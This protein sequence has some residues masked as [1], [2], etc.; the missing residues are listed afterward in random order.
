MGNWLA[1]SLIGVPV[2]L[3]HWLLF[4][5]LFIFFSGQNEKVAFA[6]LEKEIVVLFHAEFLTF[7]NALR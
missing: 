4:L 3:A 6:K 1:D 2:M 5:F 7:L